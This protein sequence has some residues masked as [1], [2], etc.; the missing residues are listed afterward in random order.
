MFV[1]VFMSFN[2]QESNKLNYSKKVT[3]SEGL[4]HN[5]VTSIL[6]AED[7]FLWIGTYEGL[8]KYDGYK[9][10]TYKNTVDKNILT[11][12]R[13]RSLVQDSKKN[14][15][16]GTDEGLTIY[17]TVEEKFEK[18]YSNK[19]IDK[20][21][22]GPIIRKV[23]IN[24][25]KNK[26]YC[27]TDGA[28]VFIFDDNYKL[29]NKLVP[30]L[31]DSKGL[32]FYDALELKNGNLVFTTT[33]G[34]YF[35]NVKNNNFR[36]I[37]NNKV[38][39]SSAIVSL[40]E[41]SFFVSLTEG[42]G[43]VNYNSKNETFTLNK[44]MYLSERFSS[45]SIDSNGD[46]WLGT[47]NNGVR[48]VNKIAN[49]I[50]FDE[51]HPLSKY[52][53]NDNVDRLRISTIQTSSNNI[54]IGSFNEGFYQFDIKE[55][56]FKKYIKELG[57][58]YGIAS[59]S[60]THISALNTDKVFVTATFGGLGLFNIVTEKFEK[61]PFNIT[62]EQILN[63]SSVFVDSKKST[64]LTIR[65][66][67][68]YRIKKGKKNLEKITSSFFAINSLTS[69]RSY[70]EDK[71]GNIW[72]GTSTDVFKVNIDSLNQ[73][74][75]I[76]ALNDNPFFK[77][78][79]LS[80][81]RYVYADPLKNLI[82]IG[83]DSDGLFRVNNNNNVAL[84][85]L[86]VSQ[87]FKDIAISSNFVTYVLRLPN[88]ELWVG[89]EGGGICKII[90]EK[91]NLEF[92]AYTEK[93][94][95]SNNV[96]KS[97][98]YDNDNNL[99]IATNILIKNIEG[100]GDA[101]YGLVHIRSGNQM[102]FKNLG[103]IGGTTLRLEGHL[104]IFESKV[105]GAD[106]MSN[107]VGRGIRGENGNAA[108][109]L[110]PHYINNGIVDIRNISYVSCGFAVRI[111]NA[112]ATKREQALGLR[113]GRFDSKS[114]I[115]GIT[116]SF[117]NTNAQLKEKHYKYLPC[118]LRSFL[119]KTPMSPDPVDHTRNFNGPSIA[120]VVNSAN[121]AINFDEKTVK[122]LKDVAGGS[123]RLKV[124]KKNNCSKKTF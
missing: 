12:N 110:S 82:W 10:I 34:L 35:L 115:S 77:K 67:G 28:G 50:K 46:F 69:F 9:L 118:S 87:F 2:A 32:H 70:T 84:S 83:A 29:I 112:F 80:L 68:L 97:M 14:L 65:D 113:N 21:I 71:F 6:K 95:L 37:L 91:D 40:N 47:V 15:W 123:G 22:K 45:F 7:G 66:E 104:D 74:K 1:S 3:I 27:L 13:V 58:K 57:Q 61:L 8:N 48:K 18:I 90:E 43:L 51:K 107:I 116:A 103:G 19:L 119:Q 93:Q 88:E 5:G 25:K 124:A 101:A 16:I 64:W 102:M 109:M 75:S 78:K 63:V 55:N 42:I 85:E 56:P 100:T 53:F 30:V 4:A 122:I 86:K 92:I 121:Y 59:N 94:G 108:V 96:V 98:Q 11:S 41:T 111:E 73:V 99:W 39:L 26:I 49:V 60:V 62:D 79:N 117:G 72:V 23:F 38:K 52:Y 17:K 105:G 114:V 81:A 36:K 89:T 31:E 20:D 54:W 33:N 44:K 120:A 24:K 106:N 76:E